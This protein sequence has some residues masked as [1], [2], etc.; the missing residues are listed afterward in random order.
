MQYTCATEKPKHTTG[1]LPLQR[2]GILQRRATPNRVIRDL[3]RLRCWNSSTKQSRWEE[4]GL[5]IPLRPAY[6][7]SR[8][9][10]SPTT[11]C[12]VV[13][14]DNRSDDG[15]DASEGLLWRRLHEIA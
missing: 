8:S 3:E 11:A 7:M 9:S 10:W 5:A 13:I 6:L 15:A 2:F 14:H 1:I 4:K 12:Q